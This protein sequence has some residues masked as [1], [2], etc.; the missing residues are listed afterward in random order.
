MVQTYVAKVAGATQALTLHGYSKIFDARA[1][2]YAT[3]DVLT[4]SSAGFYVVQTLDKEYFD[5][6]FAARMRMEASKLPGNPEVQW[7]RPLTVRLQRLFGWGDATTSFADLLHA[8]ESGDT[9]V[10]R[11]ILPQAASWIDMAVRSDSLTRA[12]LLQHLPMLHNALQTRSL[13]ML[14]DCQHSFCKDPPKVHHCCKVREH[15]GPLVACDSCGMVCCFR[16]ANA[17]LE[18]QEEQLEKLRAVHEVRGGHCWEPFSKGSKEC[19][20]CHNNATFVCHCG[21][22]RCQL[23]TKPV[24][25]PCDPVSAWQQHPGKPLPFYVIDPQ[26]ISEAEKLA[27]LRQELGDDAELPMFAQKFV[28]IFGH[29]VHGRVPQKAACL[30]LWNA[31]CTEGPRLTREVDLPPALRMAFQKVWGQERVLCSECGSVVNELY[32]RP[33]EAA[34]CSAKC[35]NSGC[36][37]VCRRCQAPVNAEWPYCTVCC[38]GSA[39]RIQ[40]PKGDSDLHMSMERQARMLEI[41]QHSWAGFRCKDLEHESEWKRRRR[42]S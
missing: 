8:T 18:Q 38:I 35:K 22:Q 39:E 15:R 36:R 1:L 4:G 19:T 17:E 13:P 41:A 24:V 10:L 2:A 16:C 6:S 20:L 25:S 32:C 27:W 23:H 29:K 5:A 3:V 31:Y 11:H 12:R 9:D 26:R 33:H 34:F 30:R 7:V 40:V 37:T 42:S 28:D 14:Q 21:A